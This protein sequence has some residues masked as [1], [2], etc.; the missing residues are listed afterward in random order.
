MTFNFNDPKF[1]QILWSAT[2]LMLALLFIAGCAGYQFKQQQQ[3]TQVQLAKV[4]VQYATMKIVKDKP[5]LA[6]SLLAELN[7]IE[8]LIETGDPV[9]VAKE[10]AVGRVT[11]SSLKPEEKLLCMNLIEIAAGSIVKVADEQQS[12]EA[13]IALE[14]IKWMRDALVIMA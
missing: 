11:G 7:T 14:V 8:K 5:D 10:Y 12:Q 9:S 4:V 2:V 1:R 3:Q 13:L 6:K